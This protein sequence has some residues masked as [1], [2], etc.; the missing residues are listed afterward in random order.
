MP[1]RVHVRAG[2]RALTVTLV[3]LTADLVGALTAEPARTV[4]DGRAES[5]P[6]PGPP[7]GTPPDVWARLREGT[8]AGLTAPVPGALD[9]A[10]VRPYLVVLEAGR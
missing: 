1:Q 2:R 10:A 4:V 9:S 7:A 8:R 6:R 5:A 3:A